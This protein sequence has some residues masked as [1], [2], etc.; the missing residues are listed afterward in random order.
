MKQFLKAFFKIKTSTLCI[1]Y[2]I[3]GITIFKKKRNS[4]YIPKIYSYDKMSV[5]KE[6]TEK[7][8]N[9]DVKNYINKISHITLLYEKGRHDFRGHNLEALLFDKKIK[10]ID[11]ENWQAAEL[12]IAL[13]FGIGADIEKLR[14]ASYINIPTFIAEEPFLRCV[15]PAGA[16]P[17]NCPQK[18]KDACSHFLDKGGSH[19]YSG[20]VTDAEKLLNS[21]F[22]LSR[23]QLEYAK[24]AINYIK[25]NK[26]SKYNCSPIK[27]PN[28]PANGKKNILVIDQ[29]F[30]DMSIDLSGGDLNCFEFMLKTA[31]SENSGANIIIKSHCDG[32][33]SCFQFMQLPDNVYFHT[34][35]VNMYS[36]LE[37]I[38]EVYVYGSAAGLEALIAGKKVHVFGS[39]IY[40][41]WGLTTDNRF[42]P[43]RQKKRTLE[44]LFFIVYVQYA[45]Y[46]NPITKKSCDIFEAMEV[47]KNLRD[48]YFSCYFK[49]QCNK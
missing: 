24:K 8:Q 19:F 39:P 49:E 10:Y 28:L 44:E 43:E 36:L 5:I 22:Q 9:I 29:V 11:D 41:G 33:K 35:A 14:T 20:C 1:K 37:K 2:K 38:D 47:L 40:A 27:N 12:F 4:P 16:A 17:I 45:F 15:V 13:P 18:F 46:C 6:I 34:D 7:F 21:D 31:I 32:R 48:E 25:E 3:F 26:L 23:E 30:G 42:F